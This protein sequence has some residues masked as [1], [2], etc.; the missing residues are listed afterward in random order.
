MDDSIRST[1]PFQVLSGRWLG[2]SRL[3]LYPGA[4]AHESETTARVSSVAQGQL[5]VIAYTWEFEA[6]P[7]DGMIVFPSAIGQKPTKSVWL[8]SWH[9]RNDIM[10]CE[11]TGDGGLVSLNGSYQAPP[12]PDWGWRIEIET[13]EDPVLGIRMFNITPDGEEALA[14][15]ARYERMDG[16]T[17]SRIQRDVPISAFSVSPWRRGLGY[18]PG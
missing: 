1:T 11:G 6:A 4:D 9:M 14:V 12:G 17:I 8:D 16:K 18:D 3:W 10:F 13:A 2:T 15:L 5:V 7:Q